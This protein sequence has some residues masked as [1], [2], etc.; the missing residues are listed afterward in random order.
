VVEPS[1]F[2]V[3]SPGPSGAFTF[4]L[5]GNGTSQTVNGVPKTLTFNTANRILTDGALSVTHDANGA[6]TQYGTAT[7]TWNA[8]HELVQVVD[9][10]TTTQFFYD[11]FGR[12]VG[13][14]VNGTLTRYV[15]LGANLCA[16]A[17]ASWNQIAAYFYQPGVDLPVT[18]TDSAGTVWYLQDLAGSVTALAKERRDALRPLPLLAVGGGGLRRPRHALPA[19][20][21]DGAGVGQHRPLLPPEPVLPGEHGRLPEVGVGAVPARAETRRA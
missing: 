19:A 3:Y 20:E 9:G 18:R 1:W 16:E 4:S 15:Y 17:D 11:C 2:T 13:K 10:G 8:R 21:V 12:R 6:V 14:S 5:A 7:L